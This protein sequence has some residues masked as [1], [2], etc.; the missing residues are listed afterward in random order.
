MDP[1]TVLFAYFTTWINTLNYTL[2]TAVIALAFLYFTQTRPIDQRIAIPAIVGGFVSI[3]GTGVLFPPSTLPQLAYPICLFALGSGCT[4]G[5]LAVTNL[6]KHNLSWVLI[7]VVSDI[8]A[9]GVMLSSVFVPLVGGSYFGFFFAAILISA[10]LSAAAVWCILHWNHRG[11]PWWISW[12][13]EGRDA[14]LRKF[15]RKKNA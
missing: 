15:R 14:F 12:D 9:Y 13:R 3:L 1:L 10:I 8:A 4:I 2:G 11:T 6:M 7:I 5:Y